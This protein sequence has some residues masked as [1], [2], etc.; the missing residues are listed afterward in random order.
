M[1]NVRRLHDDEWYDEV[2]IIVVPRYKR[3]GFG[4]CGP[5]KAPRRQGCSQNDRQR[6]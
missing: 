5:G 6:T 1:K 2:R 4:R 3:L